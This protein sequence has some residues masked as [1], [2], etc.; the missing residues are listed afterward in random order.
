MLPK[1]IQA[2][3]YKTESGRQPVREFLLD[4]SKAGRL[5]IGEDILFVELNW[6]VDRPY[7]DQL[8]KGSGPAERTIYELRSQLNEQGSNK[9]ARVLFF[10][11]DHLMVLTH[12]FIKKT[13]KVP[14]H[15]IE[16]AWKRM[17]LWVEK[18]RSL[19]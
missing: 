7:V 13:R 14:K 19:K 17:K 3:F 16:T 12:A 1:K 8:K 2:E 5:Q 10:I 6:K 15:E 9:E 11:F 4:C 18:E